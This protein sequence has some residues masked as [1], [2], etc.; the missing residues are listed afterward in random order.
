MYIF[1]AAVI[2]AGA[3]GGSIA[4]VISYSGLPVILK[5]ID[6]AMLEAGMA[7]A[8]GIY[9]ERARKGKMTAIQVEEKMALI[10]PQLDY[11]GFDDVDLVIEAV[12]EKMSVK[13][14]VFRE[15]EGICHPGAIFASNTSALSISEMAGATN[16]PEQVVGFHFFNPAHIMKL[17]EVIP[18]AQTSD[19]TVESVVTFARD[20]RKIPI[21]VKECPGFLV[22]RLL[23]PY[24]GEAI[25]ALQ[26]GAADAET[27]DGAMVEAG[28]PMGPF[29][30]TDMLGL[31][32]CDD[33]AQTLYQ[34]YGERMRP[35]ALI[36]RMVEAGRLGQKVGKGFYTYGDETGPTLQELIAQIQAETGT[37]STPFTTD[38]LILPLINE[39]VRCVEEGVASLNDIGIAMQAGAGFPQ[40]PLEMADARGLDEVLAGLEAL[41]R[42]LGDRFEPAPL[43]REKVAAG[44]LGRKTGSGFLEYT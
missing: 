41:Q 31:D 11:S 18:G 13:Q 14:A 5:D 44:E 16:R 28:M 27:I 17:V 9:E 25:F 39:A 10:T 21:I 3:M 4:Q 1:K 22:N 30:L 6:P 34:A 38:R 33:V 29:T 20:L 7:K 40:G 2:G 26:E 43:L 36:R 8:R 37:H 19:D 24:V 23:S 32:I 42:E 12:P 35:P 15:L